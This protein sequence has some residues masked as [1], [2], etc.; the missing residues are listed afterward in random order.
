MRC[1]GGFAVGVF[2]TVA[3]VTACRTPIPERR[4]VAKGPMGLALQLLDDMGEE[5]PRDH[6]Q[7]G[8]H[9]T[10]ERPRVPE[11]PGVAQ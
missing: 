1:F 9:P 10:G 3:V 7:P 11:H 6:Q 5:F 4:G 2:C 8:P